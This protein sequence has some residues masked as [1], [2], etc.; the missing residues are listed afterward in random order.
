MIQKRIMKNQRRM[1]MTKII[2]VIDQ[3]GIIPYYNQITGEKIRVLISYVYI[4]GQAYNL[5]YNY[6]DMIYEL[7]LDCGAFT[8]DRGNILLT[9]SEHRRYIHMYGQ[10]FNHTFSMDNNFNN[11]EH[12]FNNVVFLENGLPEEVKKP[13]PTIHCEKNPFGEIQI[14]ADQGYV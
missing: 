8:A 5:V 3:T 13:I 12:N 1:K 2:I 9:E 4:E 14:Y 10:L 6:R 11:P 7:Y